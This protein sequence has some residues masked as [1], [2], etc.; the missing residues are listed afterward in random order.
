MAERHRQCPGCDCGLHH[1]NRLVCDPCWRS[2]PHG[3]SQAYN[4]SRTLEDR[5]AAFRAILD[6]FRDQREQPQLDLK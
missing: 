3:L 5:R 1:R 6:H 4:Q 2:L